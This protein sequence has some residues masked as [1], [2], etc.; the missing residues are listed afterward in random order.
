MCKKIFTPEEV[1]LEQYTL[2]FALLTQVIIGQFK[3]VI[4]LHSKLFVSISPKANF[5]RPNEY[6]IFNMWSVPNT[7]IPVLRKNR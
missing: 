7:I 3:I 2:P 5:S 1:E 6:A 4:S